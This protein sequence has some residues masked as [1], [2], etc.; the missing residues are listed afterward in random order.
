MKSPPVMISLSGRVLGRASE[1]S[2]TRVDDGGGYITFHGWR[3]GYLGFSRRRQF[4]GGRAMSVGTCGPH[5][6]W[7]RGQGGRRPMVWE[8]HEPTL[9][10]LRTPCTCWKNRDFGLHFVQFREYF[11]NNFSE[12][13]KQQ[14]TGSGTMTSCQ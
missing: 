1:P 7:W 10:P 14:K 6:T 2:Q 5:T 13:Q 9:A 4:I 11:Q 8:A 3:L 12:I